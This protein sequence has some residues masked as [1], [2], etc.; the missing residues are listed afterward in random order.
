MVVFNLGGYWAT[1]TLWR[2]IELY[3]SQKTPTRTLVSFHTLN[4]MLH[5]IRK[6]WRSSSWIGLYSGWKTCWRLAPT[7]GLMNT[8]WWGMWIKWPFNIKKLSRVRTEV[9]T[10]WMWMETGLER[11]R[12][13]YSPNM[14]T[15]DM[16]KSFSA[17]PNPCDMLVDRCLNS[18]LWFKQS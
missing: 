10:L 4:G 17:T 11:S 5:A 13:N 9:L 15:K 3:F 1:T 8:Y 7:L 2:V 14:V 16:M 12:R 6:C 18:F